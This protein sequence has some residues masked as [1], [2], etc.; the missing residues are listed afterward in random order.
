LATIQLPSIKFALLIHLGYRWGNVLVL[1]EA[2][3]HYLQAGHFVEPTLFPF[4]PIDGFDTQIDKEVL[5]A[6]EVKA[7][8]EEQR[9]ARTK[10]T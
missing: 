9:K 5:S 2:I 6:S 10:S 7:Y 1:T 8:L 4:S 3:L